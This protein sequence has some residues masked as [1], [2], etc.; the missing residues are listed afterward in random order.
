M[1][2]HMRTL[3]NNVRTLN[4]VGGQLPFQFDVIRLDK[5]LT[6]ERVHHLKR[7]ACSKASSNIVDD[8]LADYSK[9]FRRFHAAKYSEALSTLLANLLYAYG[10]NKGVLYS[11][12]NN[13]AKGDRLIMGLVDYLAEC[14]LVESIIQ[15]PNEVGCSS[16]ALP[17]PELKRQLDIAKVR[18]AKGKNHK[19]LILRD[20]NKKE[21]STARL[22]HYTP[23][24]FKQLTRPADLHNEWWNNNSATIRKQPVIPFL[25]R[26]FNKAFDLG[27]RYY[28]SHQGISS[29]DRAL[30]LFNGKPTV[31]IDYS[32]M[33]I[34]ILYAWAGVG[35]IGD[36]YSIEGYERKTVKAIMLR[37]VNIE[38]MGSLKAIIT[39]SAK[40]SRKAEFSKYKSKRATFEK[41]AAS[42]LKATPP[43]KPKWLDSHIKNI[44]TGFNA[45]AFIQSLYERHSAISH[46]LGNKDVG[47]KLQAADSALMGV[48]MNDLYSQKPP[49]PVLPV[50]DS[51]I[52]RKTNSELVRL[53][54]KHHFKEMFGISIEV[55][56]SEN[57]P[58]PK[59][60]N[61]NNH[62]LV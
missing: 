51:L 24:K 14:G 9:R 62:S 20:E 2:Q 3:I 52:C 4:T 27:G 40:E 25:H 35:I 13:S 22:E 42:H 48:I 53:T 38:N 49:V 30:I 28:G 56:V 21:L 41:L 17:L 50:H 10:H 47:L 45:K 19:P 43:R 34:A 11:R 37:L 39:N 5:T 59:P 18:I 31:E 29:N 44:P 61:D 8:L 46:L 57:K 55:T 26:V 6:L 1:T 16:Y 7:I 32:S 60:D 58:A 15:P 36:P 33:H 54:M 23:N 12:N